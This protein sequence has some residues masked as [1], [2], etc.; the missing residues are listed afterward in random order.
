[1]VKS[2]AKTN[3][4]LRLIYRASEELI[5]ED[6]VEPKIAQSMETWAEKSGHII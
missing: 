2:G 3:E 1:M 5:L 4:K 6:F